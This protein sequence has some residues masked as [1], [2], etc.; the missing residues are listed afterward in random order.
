M[1]NPDRPLTEEEYLHFVE[2]AIK[3]LTKAGH[4]GPRLDNLIR[5]HAHRRWR[6]DN[7]GLLL[8]PKEPIS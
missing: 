6:L 5:E 3:R 2:R 1:E 7:E 4:T 8:T